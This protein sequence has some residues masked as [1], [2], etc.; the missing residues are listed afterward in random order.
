MSPVGITLLMLLGFAGFGWLAWR[1]LRIV[2]ALAPDVRWADAGER[3]LSVLVNGLLQQRMLRREWRPG[4]MHAVIFL[5]FCSLLLRKLQL[6]AI[7]YFEPASF[8]DAFGGPFAAFKDGVELAVTAAVLYAFWRRFVLRPPRLEPNREAILVLGLILTIMVTDFAFDAFRFARLSPLHA[9]VAHEQGFAFIGGALAQAA[10]GLSAPAQAVGY[11]LSYW[12]QMAVVF[13]FLV[14]LPAGEHFHIV[15]ALPVLFFRRGRP[16][17]RVPSVD[18]A[19]LMEATDEADMKA[20]VRTVRDLT[21][22]EGLDAFTCTECGRCKDACPTHLTGKP[23]SLKKVHDSVKHHLLEQGELIVAGDPESKLPALVGPVIGEET[24]WACTSCGY[25]EAACPIELEHLDKFFRMRQHQVMIVGEFPHELKKV[26]E[27]WESQGNAWGLASDQRGDWARELGVP[28]VRS[29][30]DMEG[31]ELLFYVGSAMSYDPRGQKIAR[32]FVSVLQHAGVRFG[33][34]GAREG[35]TGEC[36]RR[37]GNEML[38]Q[39][40]ATGLVATLTEMGVKRIVTCDPHALNSLRNEYPEFGGH[41]EVVHHTALIAELMR[42][43]RVK[44]QPSPQRVVF[45]D[46][47]YLGRHNGE[48]DAPREVLARLAGGTPPLEFVLAREK[49]MCCGAG[50]GRMWMEETTGTR[51]NVARAEQALAQA[52]EVVATACPYCAVM[53]GDG[54]AAARP[55]VAPPTR[56]IA[57]LVAEA[58]TQPA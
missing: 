21:W 20:G 40:L 56:D 29:A 18:I 5:G 42:Q 53:M 14:L 39:Q 17:H 46:P 32:A 41:Y 23:L 22:K 7:G 13:A 57:E 9:S 49:S 45:H 25:C 48:F 43:G 36:A 28:V 47:C 10:A 54:L 52:P 4:L 31:L 12:L 8:P 15:T 3:A 27:A 50:G 37:V 30:A 44:L 26:F 34:L 11:H 19:K 2:I 33:I 58:L 16:A 51:I 6:I 24:L 35:S 1:K 55:D 38:F